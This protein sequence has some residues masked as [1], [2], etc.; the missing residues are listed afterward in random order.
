M[1][2]RTSFLL[3]CAVLFGE[4]VRKHTQDSQYS[5]S[6]VARNRFY[7]ARAKKHSARYIVS[8]VSSVV[9]G[10]R[11]TRMGLKIDDADQPYLHCEWHANALT[12]EPRACLA[13]RYGFSREMVHA[14]N[15]AQIDEIVF[16][17]TRHQVTNALPRAYQVV[18]VGNL[19][20][21]RL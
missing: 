14:S 20:R 19:N 13:T 16:C 15:K 9:V 21:G 12:S 5:R 11:N 7:P 2:Y 18:R 3:S 1:S 4:G 6:Y 8:P 10:H 17:R